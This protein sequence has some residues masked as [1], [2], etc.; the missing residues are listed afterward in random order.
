MCLSYHILFSPATQSTYLNAYTQTTPR[1]IGQPGSFEP[2]QVTRL[3]CRARDITLYSPQE[4]IEEALCREG[5]P[6]EQHL[7]AEQAH[8]EDGG[9]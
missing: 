9:E 4:H 1:R 2:G 7:S 3:C 6:G 8:D 5:L